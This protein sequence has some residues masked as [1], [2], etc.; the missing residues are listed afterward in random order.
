[1]R[2]IV[3]QYYREGLTQQEIA[4]Q[5]DVKQYTVSRR[6]SSAKEALLLALAQWSQEHLHTALTS[7]AVKA[8]SIVLEEWLQ[9]KLRHG[10]D[11]QSFLGRSSNG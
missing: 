4:T 7:P 3:E 8:M 9:D 1:M 10:N 2:Q 6:L 11:A 5:L